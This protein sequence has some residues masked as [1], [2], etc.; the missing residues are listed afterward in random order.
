MTRRAYRNQ[1]GEQDLSLYGRRETVPSIPQKGLCACGTETTRAVTTRDGHR[2][3]CKPCA[4]LAIRAIYDRAS[5]KV[6]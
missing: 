2:W 3:E 6:G 4:E 1:G 5:R